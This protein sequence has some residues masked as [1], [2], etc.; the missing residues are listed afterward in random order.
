MRVVDPEREPGVPSG[1]TV[2][3]APLNEFSSDRTV[4]VECD[5]E[6]GQVVEIQQSYDL[7]NWFPATKQ[8]V[9]LG[10]GSRPNRFSADLH[11]NLPYDLSNGCYFRA[12]T[13]AAP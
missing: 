4:H 5:A 10:P 2:T 6:F 1:L 13:Y 11:V 8:S 12:R 7:A 3:P 9:G